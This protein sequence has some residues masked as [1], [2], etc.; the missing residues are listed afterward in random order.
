MGSR[1]GPCCPFARTAVDS[2]G[3]LDPMGPIL[4]SL[5]GV[6]LPQE[7]APTAV[8]TPVLPKL[9]APIQVQAD[10]GP[11]TAVTGHAA[12]FV[13]DCDGDGLRDLVVGMFGNDGDANGGAARVYK[14]V[15]SNAAPKFTTSAP[16][17][18]DGKLALMESS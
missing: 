7:P 9:A 16:L 10:G 17:L 2:T 13:V 1:G 8:P 4:L 14:N 5:C 6:L 12:P 11:I 3:M 18:A 15:G